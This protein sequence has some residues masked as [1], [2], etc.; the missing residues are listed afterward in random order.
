MPCW[1]FLSSKT[2][3][4]QTTSLTECTRIVHYC[5]LTWFCR[6]GESVGT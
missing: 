5:P 6:F 2:G 1:K 4:G 3:I